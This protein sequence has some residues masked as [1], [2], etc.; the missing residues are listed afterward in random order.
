[1]AQ[2]EA[3]QSPLILWPALVRPLGDDLLDFAR[4]GLGKIGA[5]DREA[6]AADKCPVSLLA[7]DSKRESRA[8]ARFDHGGRFHDDELRFGRVVHEPAL[9]ELRFRPDD[10][11]RKGALGAGARGDPG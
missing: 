8:L 9:L 5:G 3:L 11:V 4:E 7:P 1:M 10:L 2:V 6:E